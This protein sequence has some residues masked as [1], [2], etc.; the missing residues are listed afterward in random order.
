MITEH[1]ILPTLQ[2]EPLH[3]SKSDAGSSTNS[4]PPSFFFHPVVWKIK[5]RPIGTQDTD[6]MPYNNR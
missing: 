6:T 4:C 2:L 5:N 1:F 3:K